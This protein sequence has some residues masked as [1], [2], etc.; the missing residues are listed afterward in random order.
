V[1][2]NWTEFWRHQEIY[3]WDLRGFSWRKFKK[4]TRRT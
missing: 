2:L 4:Y 3:N 1:E